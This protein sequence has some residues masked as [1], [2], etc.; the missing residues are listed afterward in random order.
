LAALGAYEVQSASIASTKGDGLRRHYGIGGTGTRFWDL[1]AEV[2]AIHADWTVRALAE[3]VSG[4]RDVVGDVA[5]LTA[6]AWWDFLSERE[7]LAPSS[8]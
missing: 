4:E 6:G 1:H 3:L 5:A 2:D 7:S 8:L